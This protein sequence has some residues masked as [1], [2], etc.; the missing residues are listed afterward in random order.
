[1]L[2]NKRIR[3]YVSSLIPDLDKSEN[4]FGFFIQNVKK[5]GTKHT[6]THLEN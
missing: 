3:I 2:Q 6:R 5:K 1:M 4:I